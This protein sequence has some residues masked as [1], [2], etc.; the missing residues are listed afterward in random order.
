MPLLNYNSASS[1]ETIFHA[2]RIIDFYAKNLKEKG[3][4]SHIPATL[5]AEADHHIDKIEAI[6]D[7]IDSASTT[8]IPST[9]D[10]YKNDPIRAAIRRSAGRDC[11]DCKPTLPMI[12]FNGMK[13]QVFADAKDF[14]NKLKSLKGGSFSM[15]LPSLAFLFSSFCIPDLIKLLSL[16]LAS[17]IRL[18]FSL[19]ISKF[20]FMK[21]LMAILSK[22]L[23]NLLK[24]A[25][26]SVSFSLSSIMCVL[27]AFVQLNE[28]LVP[29]KEFNLG[30]SI[31]NEGVSISDKTEQQRANAI[32][33]RDNAS[34][35]LDERSNTTIFLGTGIYSESIDVEN[36][37]FVKK[38]RQEVKTRLPEQKDVDNIKNVVEDVQETI[39]KALIDM[40]S[41]IFEIFNIGQAIQCESERST[42]KASDSIESIMKWLQMIN[43]IRSVIKKKTRIIA[44]HVIQSPSYNFYDNI[45]F[46]AEDVAEVV[47]EAV[48][49]MGVIYST[50]PGDTGVLLIDNNDNFTDKPLSLYSCNLNEFVES[51]H[52]DNIIEDA[53][54]F[55]E[56]NL[57]GQGNKPSY[58]TNDYIPVGNEEF[59]PFNINEDDVLKQ[60]ADILKFLN[61]K[62]P[63]E[64]QSTQASQEIYQNKISSTLQI[65]NKI[66]TVLGEI[67]K[68]KI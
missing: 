8:N 54:T 15:A 53:K 47:G 19:D 29:Q 59:I 24:F 60:I 9:L 64:E 10:K 5:Y 11:L 49:K 25:H 38:L 4:L 35:Q 20:S 61:I 65:S 16:L 13:G 68:I 57:V 28:S 33:E 27:D 44:K 43:L 36:F 45:Q 58:F 52:L 67:G 40:E 63:Y 31:T 46:T 21:L 50:E 26:T 23:A 12:R 30:M 32:A 55:A 37:N 41:A 6:R 39:N 7:A 66:D 14:L 1:E 62:N 48:G 17:I 22:L 56:N 51:S 18:T 2:Q 34:R 3:C 42:R